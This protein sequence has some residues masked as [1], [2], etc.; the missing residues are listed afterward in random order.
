LFVNSFVLVLYI[1]LRGI[2]IYLVSLV[3]FLTHEIF[4]V[5]IW[6]L[7][8]KANVRSQLGVSFPAIHRPCGSGRR[9]LWDDEDD[10][11]RRQRHV[12]RPTWPAR[13]RLL[14][15]SR[16]RRRHA[17]YHA[18]AAAAPAA[19]RKLT[20]H[21]RYFSISVASFFTARN[22]FQSEEFR[23][24]RRRFTHRSRLVAIPFDIWA[25]D[26]STLLS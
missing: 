21:L 13:L 18:P 3:N 22:L 9:R 14:L 11:K 4:V 20:E 12:G 23:W 25:G 17:S 24:K 8:V 26:G 10:R 19:S 1:H 16:W 5:L 2:K 6:S 15:V 7:D